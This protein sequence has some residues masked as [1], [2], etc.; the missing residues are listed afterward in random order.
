MWVEENL[1]ATS[2]LSH[3]L[4]RPEK[5]GSARDARRRLIVASLASLTSFGWGEEGP[6]EGLSGGSAYDPV[7]VVLGGSFDGFPG[8]AVAA[9]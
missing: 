9:G 4:E 5:A 6:L 1:G 3:H 7:R 2:G 8:S